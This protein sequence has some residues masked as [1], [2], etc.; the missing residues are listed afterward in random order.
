MQRAHVLTQETLDRLIAKAWISYLLIAALQL[1]VIWG[2]WR[3]RDITG[4]DTSSYFA[5]A[6]RWYRDFTTD[7]VWSPFYTSFYGTIYLLT[8]DVYTPPFST[9]HYRDAGGSWCAGSLARTA[10]AGLGPGNRG[11]VGSPADQ[12]RSSLRG[13]SLRVFARAC[14]VDCRGIERHVMDARLCARHTC[15]RDLPGPFGT[16]RRR[17]RLC[18]DLLVPGGPC[19]APRSGRYRSA[20][21]PACDRYLL[22]RLIAIGVC[23][24]FVRCSAAIDPSGQNRV[25]ASRTILA[26][27]QSFLRIVDERCLPLKFSRRS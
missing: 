11:V 18:L 23:A 12:F 20:L 13:P 10:D 4:G 22:P 9:R 1:K 3:L 26:V 17:H 24:L 6:Y 7:P 27:A 5:S 14:C 8:G 2:I 21:A 15:R 19:L 25:P 16:D